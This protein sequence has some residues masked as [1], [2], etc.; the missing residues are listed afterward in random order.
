MCKIRLIGLH[1]ENFKRAN[2][3][4]IAFD[5]ESMSIYGQNAAGKTTIYDALNWLLFDK[6]SAGVKDFDIKPRDE[7]GELRFPG[8]HTVVSA[9]FALDGDTLELKK[10]YYERWTQQRGKADRVFAGNSSDYFVDGVPVKK[11]QY[12]ERIKAMIDEQL[13]RLLTDV[14]Q[15]NAK[16]DW[17]ERRR[18][19]FDL[20]GVMTDAE[21]LALGGDKYA[22]LATAIGKGT[23]DDLKAKTASVR[24]NLS[25]QKN[26]IPVRI[27]ECRKTVERLQ[28]LDF[29]AASIRK[30]SAA[31]Q[32]DILRAELMRLD[33]DTL[34]REK[35][36][37]IQA[38]RNTLRTLEMEN[39][40]HRRGQ[41]PDAL[42][43]QSET[44]A[45]ELRSA[46]ALLASH[47]REKQGHEARVAHLSDLMDSKRRQWT[48]LDV[49]AISL[50]TF[51]PTCRRAYD[52][53]SIREA[54]KQLEAQK[55][56]RLDGIRTDGVELKRQYDEA[57]SAA[58]A[59]EAVM[60]EDR[61]TAS[62]LTAAI[63]DCKAKAAAV[64]IADLPDYAARKTALDTELGTLS[65][66]LRR[67][68]ENR[69]AVRGEYQVKISTL[70]AAVSDAD[71]ILASKAT[72]ESTRK[73]IVELQAEERTTAAEIERLDKLLFL[74]EEFTT[75]KVSMIEE[76]INGRFTL[77][78][79]KLFDVQ[80]NG[81]VVDCCEATHD[82][83][84]YSDLNDG[85]K[86]N[87]G[88]DIIQT[89]SQHYGVS[90]PLFVD[91]AESVTDLYRID[92]QVIRL[93]VSEN[94]R[95][96]RFVKWA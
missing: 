13:F 78:R 56:A 77:A 2:L 67:M 52:P 40:A 87:I 38:R 15:F 80:I 16:L 35:E 62:E 66:E 86:V 44:L 65:G 27:D 68:S 42:L 59:M 19:L 57:M 18:V 72:L 47:Q 4:D 36:N 43:A 9:A 41:R 8:A 5:G 49:C 64:E 51:C 25:G 89:L 39:E 61:R 1:I 79:F 55:Q 28:D 12:D 50:E 70:N 17:R 21:L 29:D 74:C 88:L 63:A 81:A 90:V 23:I 33:N 71:G 54:R 30:A 48:E 58:Q 82:G 95:E 11:Y 76:S 3:L 91:K 45:G 75:F 14:H 7:S 85:M 24:K 26:T 31:A 60:A 84:A 53:E 69:S 32:C 94:D 34:L 73:R 93:V 96:L 22:E 10:E 83:V 6:N 92:T 46:N 20:C 37:A